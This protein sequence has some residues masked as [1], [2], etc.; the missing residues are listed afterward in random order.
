MSML[1]FVKGKVNFPITL[2]PTIWIFDDRKLLLEQAFD[3]AFMPKSVDADVA[4][5]QS[6]MAMA[7]QWDFDWARSNPEFRIE[8]KKMVNRKEIEGDWAMYIG[9]FL[10]NAEP[11]DDTQAVLLHL[12]DGSQ[13]EITLEEAMRGIACFAMNG[14]A[15]KEDGPI[16]FYH[17]DGRNR[18]EPIRNVEAFEFI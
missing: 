6:A 12:K 8:Q 9:Q 4:L 2:D 15:L 5:Q 1:V 13:V 18:N 16:H 17:G 10:Q 7:K 14:R 11:H 3:P